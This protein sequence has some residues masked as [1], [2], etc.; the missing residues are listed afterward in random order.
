M[1]LYRTKLFGFY[2]EAGKLKEQ[3]LKSA[4]AKKRFEKWKE[5][6]KRVYDQLKRNSGTERIETDFEKFLRDQ[7]AAR[8]KYA[9]LRK[10]HK[11]SWSSDGPQGVR[12]E[13]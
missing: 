3:Y 2:D 7:S 11:G 4:V 10:E 9:L 8:D 1:I 13:A 6:M 5:N 12:V